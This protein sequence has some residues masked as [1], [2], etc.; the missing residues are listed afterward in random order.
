MYACE[1]LCVVKWCVCIDGFLIQL[2]IMIQLRM[3]GKGFGTF[4]IEGIILSLRDLKLLFYVYDLL[5]SSN[6]SFCLV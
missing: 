1:C 5:L 3:H 2:I 6:Y 4:A